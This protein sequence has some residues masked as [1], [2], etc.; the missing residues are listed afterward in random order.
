MKNS[1]RVSL[2]DI[3]EAVGKLEDKIDRKIEG[4]QTEVNGLQSFR[5]RWLGYVSAISFI[6]TLTF[7]LIWKKITGE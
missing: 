6:I 4:I 7:S 3:Y 1:D 5:D 2:R